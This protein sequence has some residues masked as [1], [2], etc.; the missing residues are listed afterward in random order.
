MHKEEI[1]GVIIKEL[2][3]YPQI[4]LLAEGGAK[5]FNRYDDLSDLDLMADV[6]D[7]KA[8][9]TVKQ[10]ENFLEK[11]AGISA[12]YTAAENKDFQHKF[13]KLKGTDRFSII[14]LFI[15]ERSNPAKEL[16]K[17]IHGE[18]LVHYDRYGYMNDQKFDMDTFQHKVDA[19]KSKSK[20]VF[21]FFLFQAE[22]EILRGRYI[23]ALAYYFDL[24]LKPLIRLLR[25]KYN[26]VHYNFELRYL[27]DELPEKIVK[28][29]E[30]LFSIKDIDDLKIKY[31]MLI[32][33]YKREIVGED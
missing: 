15:V 24:M 14:D 17:K 29:I 30:E 9:E 1:F 16:D 6:E 3:S 13:Y 11:L 27:Y 23:D 19:F 8:G 7:G 25:I 4:N 22:K 31:D 20:N 5:A 21:E 12:I 28:E 26:P 18:F 2:L 32:D 10:F 33:I